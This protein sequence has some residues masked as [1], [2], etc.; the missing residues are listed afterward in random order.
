MEEAPLMRFIWQRS[1]W[2]DMI[3]IGRRSRQFVS[4]PM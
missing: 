3:A 1:W 4:T 2:V